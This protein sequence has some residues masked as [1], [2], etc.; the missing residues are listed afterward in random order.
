MWQSKAETLH[1]FIA[2]QPPGP[3]E[4]GQK[5]AEA[6]VVNHKCAH[7][8]RLCHISTSCQD[9]SRTWPPLAI[10]GVFNS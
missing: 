10:A 5:R 8:Q 3:L 7:C 1:D 2:H 6:Q 4:S 9:L